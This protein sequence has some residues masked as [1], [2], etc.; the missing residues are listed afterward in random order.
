MPPVRMKITAVEAAVNNFPGYSKKNFTVWIIDSSSG[1]LKFCRLLKENNKSKVLR[2]IVEIV[3]EFV[4][5]ITL[6]VGFVA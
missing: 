2:R 1:R 3:H 4:Q 5:Y 6:F